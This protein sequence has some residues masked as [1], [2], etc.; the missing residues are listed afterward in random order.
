[1]KK[2]I[3]IA[4]LLATCF[5]SNS[6]TKDFLKE[7]PVDEIYANNLLVNYSG[8]YSMISAQR[9]LMRNEHGRFSATA[10]SPNSVFNGA[11]IF[12]LVTKEYLPQHGGI[13]LS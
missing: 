6:C 10:I 4:I 9:G 1:M 11:Q 7:R 12:I 2:I 13:G 8:F 5:I 3:I